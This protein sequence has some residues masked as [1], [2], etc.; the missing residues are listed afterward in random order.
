MDESKRGVATATGQELADKYGIKFFETSA[1]ADLNVNHV[2][3]SIA[4]DIIHRLTETN[5]MS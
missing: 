1:K 5:S 4:H 2:F 3:F